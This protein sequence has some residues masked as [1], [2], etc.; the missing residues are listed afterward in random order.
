MIDLSVEF[1]KTYTSNKL[2]IINRNQDIIL[3]KS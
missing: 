2:I 3:T 1:L